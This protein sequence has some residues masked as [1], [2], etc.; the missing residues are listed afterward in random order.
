MGRK[1]EGGTEDGRPHN[2][3]PFSRI[4]T[5]ISHPYALPTP[6][7][8]TYTSSASCNF[9]L[10]SIAPTLGPN[11]MIGIENMDIYWAY[12]VWVRSLNIQTFSIPSPTKAV[13]W[14]SMARTLI[15]LK[16]ANRRKDDGEEEWICCTTGRTS[17]TGARVNSLDDDEPI[18]LEASFTHIPT[19][20]NT[21]ED[22]IIRGWD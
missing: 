13:T 12:L 1:C 8:H 20:R 9:C 10:L 15:S 3:K 7:H 2:L 19:L 14:I 21:A 11:C 18:D 22:L 6:F 4:S 17:H 5:R 16:F